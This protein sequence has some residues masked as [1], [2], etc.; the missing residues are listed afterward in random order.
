MA[1]E[2]SSY[3]TER[4]SKSWYYIYMCKKYLSFRPTYSHGS[5]KRK[6]IRTSIRLHGLIIEKWSHKIRDKRVLLKFNLYA[7]ETWPSPPYI[8]FSVFIFYD[9][10]KFQKY[11]WLFLFSLKIRFK[12]WRET[13]KWNSKPCLVISCV[14]K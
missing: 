13:K 1:L 2:S 12:I 8:T 5:R 6:D 7:H 10:T 9:F 14:L 4:H 11:L 3:H